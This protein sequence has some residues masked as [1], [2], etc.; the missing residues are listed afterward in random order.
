MTTSY[1]QGD[2]LLTYDGAEAGEC[3]ES[4]TGPL[5]L[6]TG[7]KSGHAHVLNG[8]EMAFHAGFR[9]G[10]SGVWLPGG[11]TLT[12]DEHGA[13]TL[14]VGRYRVIRQRQ[15]SYEDESTVDD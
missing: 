7:E 8:S 4:A 10:I 9:E 15:Y 12:H 13:I 1:R 14:P 5:V 11:G 2:I 6:A 3:W